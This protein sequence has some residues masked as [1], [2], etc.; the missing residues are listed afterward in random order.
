VAAVV[1]DLRGRHSD[2]QAVGLVSHGGTLS[3]L[4]CSVLGLPPR[5]PQPFRLSNAS[6]SVLEFRPRGP[7]LTLLNDTHHLDG[8]A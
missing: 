3:M 5:R 7:V 8:L 1:D 2:N 4:V 6:L